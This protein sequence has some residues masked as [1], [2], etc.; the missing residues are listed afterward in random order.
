[1]ISTLEL[2]TKDPS[3]PL[4]YINL[5]GEFLAAGLSEQA[6]SVLEEGAAIAD[7]VPEYFL[8]AADEAV[9]NDQSLA[10]LLILEQ[11]LLHNNESQLLVV[12]ASPLLAGTVR[13]DGALEI[14]ESYQMN[15]PDWLAPKV[16]SVRWYVNHDHLPQAEVLIRGLIDGYPD[17]PEVRFT[18]G[19]YLSASGEPEAAIEQFQYVIDTEDASAL[20][21]RKA[22]QQILRIEGGNN[23]RL[24]STPSG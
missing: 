9:A 22:E 17:D 20:L 11:G 1:M 2:L 4:L 18:Y 13:Q 12:K 3:D 24:S 5:F 21:R 14:Y 10:A 16:A 23:S 19:E 6:A 8:E 7:Y 15:F